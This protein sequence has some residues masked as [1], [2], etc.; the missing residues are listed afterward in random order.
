MTISYIYTKVNKIMSLLESVDCNTLDAH[1]RGRN[2]KS[3][4][5][6]Y[7]TLDKLKDELIRER[8]KLKQQSNK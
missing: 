6:A 4:N 8:V 5:E 1:R 3:I 7:F 2:Q